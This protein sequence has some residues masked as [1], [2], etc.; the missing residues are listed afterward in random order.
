MTRLW[1]VILFV[2]W[3]GFAQS[4]STPEDPLTQADSLAIFELLDSLINLESISLPSQ[5][6]VRVGY[7]SNINAKNGAFYLYEFGITTRAAFYHK[8]GAFIDVTGY[9]SNQYQSAYYLTT[10]SIGY[11]N[12]DLKH[13]S[14]LIEYGHN[15]YNIKSKSDIITNSN[16]NYISQD[17]TDLFTG[18]IFYQWKKLN[19]KIDYTLLTGLRTAH[20]FNP[21]LYFNIARN[22][23]LGFDR[24]TITPTIAFLFGIQKQEYS[25]YQKL[26]ASP[27]EAI[28]RVRHNLPLFQ[29][30]SEEYNWSGLMNYSFRLPINFT[31]GSWGISLTYVY[32]IPTKIPEEIA[33]SEPGGSLYLSAVRYIEVKPHKK[34]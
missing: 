32:N 13:W 24:I 16:T 31:K 3:T 12:Y 18:G 4:T 28:F 22:R 33:V 1:L 21:A 27:L 14:F 20:R 23:W 15:I 30:V 8:S 2:P 10:P 6:A 34:N 26:Y 19:L 25:Y 29:L 17:F 5:F 7:N 11:M 9:L